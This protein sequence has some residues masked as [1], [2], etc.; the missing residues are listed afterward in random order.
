MDIVERLR[1]LGDH[2]S[3]EPHMHH[4][5][6]DEIERLREENAAY[7]KLWA[8]SNQLDQHI[9]EDWAKECN[10]LREALKFYADEKHYEPTK[11]WTTSF[12]QYEPDG[13]KIVTPVLA[14]NGERA[15]DAL[16]SND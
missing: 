10:C 13:Y 7:K 3:F 2:A 9:S 4:K 5:A 8:V 11:V 6:A 16:V 14:D 12:P 1:D 15:R